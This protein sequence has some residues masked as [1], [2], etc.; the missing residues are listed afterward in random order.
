M[1]LNKRLFIGGGGSVDPRDHFNTVLYT[2]D[3]SASGQDITG[4]GFQPDFV[5]TKRRSSASSHTVVDSVR[6]AN[7]RLFPDLTNSASTNPDFSF[8]SD[9]FNTN[10]KA[11]QI[12]RIQT[13]RVGSI[14]EKLE[15]GSDPGA[16]AAL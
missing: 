6:G 1:S 12:R 13:I 5:W 14:F 4:V 7:S 11:M 9:G 16:L 2:G 10:D 3:G 8:N 15:F